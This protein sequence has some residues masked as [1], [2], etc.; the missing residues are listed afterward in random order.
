MT[1]TLIIISSVALVLLGT[2]IWLLARKVQ[3]ATD[4]T[5]H[6]LLEML[7]KDTQEARID[8]RLVQESSQNLQ[9]DMKSVTSLLQQFKARQEERNREESE[10]NVAIKD[11]IKSIEHLFKGSKSKGMAGENI[12]REIFKIFPPELIVFDYKVEGKP[13]EFQIVDLNLT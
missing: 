10:Y 2:V 4:N 8:Q 13:V 12:L 11:S 7:I 3:P 9:T 1:I 6:K 5:A